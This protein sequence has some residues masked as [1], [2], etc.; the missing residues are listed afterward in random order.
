MR[1]KGAPPNNLFLK[2]LA[3]ERTLLSQAMK[4]SVGIYVVLC[5]DDVVHVNDPRGGLLSL[6]V[7]E[8][9]EDEKKRS[10]GLT[11]GR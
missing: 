10:A 11:E 6:F 9:S 8:K 1:R 2:S 4:A 7:S 5:I 3:M